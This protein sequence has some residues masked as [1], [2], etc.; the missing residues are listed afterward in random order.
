MPLID[1]MWP[2]AFVAL[3]FVLAGQ[4]SGG[5]TSPGEPPSNLQYSFGSNSLVRDSGYMAVVYAPVWD[6]A[7]VAQ[8]GGFDAAPCARLISSEDFKRLW[9]QLNE[10]NL[11]SV[12]SPGDEAF[13]HTP[14]D[15]SH[16]E[17][18]RLIVD[19]KA[20]IDWSKLD[21]Q[22]KASV[23][24]PLDEFN[25]SLKSLWALRSQDLVVP[26]EFLLELT[27]SRSRDTR[28]YKF[29]WAQGKGAHVSPS[30]KDT[31][32]GVS[33]ERFKAFW[34]ELVKENALGRSYRSTEVKEPGKGPTTVYLIRAV[35]NR[36]TVVDIRQGEEFEGR[37]LFD[38]LM[39]RLEALAGPHK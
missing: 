17:A 4:N 16:I 18:L 15:M 8:P 37:R 39:T 34:S 31:G 26:E 11:A 12:A 7:Q 22:L 19:G 38:S 25:D 30:G 10:I 35:V 29:D 20:M 28:G 21:C 23:R 5:S 24:R 9:R 1:I 32:I 13:E 6:N 2:S 3:A 36:V 33:P 27:I 14:P